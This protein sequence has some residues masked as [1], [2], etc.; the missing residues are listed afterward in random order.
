MN[1]TIA[2]NIN[3]NNTIFILAAIALFVFSY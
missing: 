1:K 2:A 3:I